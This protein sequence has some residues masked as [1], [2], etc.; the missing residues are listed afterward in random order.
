MPMKLEQRPKGSTIE[1]KRMIMRM[2]TSNATER[3]STG[4]R[5]KSHYQM[6]RPITLP[7]TPW[8]KH[9]KKPA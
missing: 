5:L 7:A 2:A 9:G 6:P 8:T 4:G 1:R 3:Y